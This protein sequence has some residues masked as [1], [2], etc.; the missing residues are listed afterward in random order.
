MTLLNYFK[1]ARESIIANKLRSFLSMLGIIIGV[2]SVILLMAVGEGAQQGIMDQMASLINNNITIQPRGGFTTRTDEETH[3]YVK[4]ITLTPELA[5][6]IEEAFPDLSGAVTYGATTLGQVSYGNNS[7]MSSFAWVPLDYLQKM[8]LTLEEGDSFNQSDFDNVEMVA[9]VNKNVVDSLFPAGNALGQKITYNNRDYTIIG[10]LSDASILWMVYIPITTYWQKVAGNRDISAITVRLSAEANNAE[11]TARVQYFL[12]RKY[13]VKHLDLAGFSLSSTAAVG[14]VIDS[15][16]AIFSI[17]LGAIGWISL[18]VGGIWV[19]NI[20]LVSVT[21][22]TREIWI[23]KAIGA[24][25]KD[26]IQQFLIESVLVTFFGGLIAIIFSLLLSWGINSLQI[27]YGDNM[28]FQV[29][30]TAQVAIIAFTLTFVVGILSGILPA[31]K[32]A[33]LK[34]IEALRFE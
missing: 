32:A 19:M 12:L 8:A 31:R 33:N 5:D 17:L 11:R 30:V 21:E 20:M 34:P 29:A 25:N 6:E 23:K 26:I 9:I 24:L 13:N 14:D 4:A 3:G 22:R 18:L 16:M 2:S 28:T 10:T 15:A 1:E 7:S 27:S